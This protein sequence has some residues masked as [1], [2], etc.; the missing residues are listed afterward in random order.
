MRGSVWQ[1]V[2]HASVG[3]V[4]HRWHMGKAIHSQSL[5]SGRLAAD[6]S[7][8]PG[9]E[10]MRHGG[11]MGCH[12]D[13]SSMSGVGGCQVVGCSGYKT[14]HKLTLIDSHNLTVSAT[15]PSSN[16]KLKPAEHRSR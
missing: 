1:A 10:H 8:R 16:L 15:V 6:K 5:Q 14:F 7:M 12:M 3:H 11:R 13:R 2:G 4:A 9:F